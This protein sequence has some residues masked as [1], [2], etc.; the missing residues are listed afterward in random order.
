MKLPLTVWGLTLGQALLTTGNILLVSVSALIGLQIA[1]SAA[2]TTF[3]VAMQF[4]GLMLVVLPAAHLMQRF[5]RKVVFMVGN[6]FGVAGAALAYMAL[7]QQSFV[8]FSVA[9][10]LLGMAIGVSQQYRFAAV[11]H[12][13]P[14]QRANAVSLVMGGGVLAAVLGPNLAIWVKSD[15]PNQQYLNAFVAL[16]VLYVIAFILVLCLPLKKNKAADSTGVTRSYAELFKQPLLVAAVVSGTIGYAVM[17]LLMTATPLAMM[18]HGFHFEHSAHV[19]QWHV[20]GMFVPSFIT[21]TLITRFGEKTI[22]LLGCVLLLLCQVVAQLGIE[23]M[24]FTVALVVLGIGWNFTFI[25]A[26]TLLT[27]THTPA[28]KAK[29]QGINDFLIFSFA[30]MAS[31]FSGYWQNLLGW[32]TLNLIMMPCVVLAVLLIYR[33]FRFSSNFKKVKNV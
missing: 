10:F 3:P 17:V 11:E 8:F 5:G 23:Y 25:G 7:L 33:G 2:W 30:A 14:A 22:M 26:T 27:Q 1:P 16:L 32:Q 15:V 31:L 29:V 18:S 21:G 13:E 9:T 20:L 24:H 6:T 12:T 4:L 19:I 28:E